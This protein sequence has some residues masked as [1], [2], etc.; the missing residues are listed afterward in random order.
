MSKRF[1]LSDIKVKV[2]SKLKDRSNDPYFIKKADESKAFLEKVG[3]PK[4]LVNLKT[5]SNN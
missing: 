4:E 3:F 1:S 5:K 2:S